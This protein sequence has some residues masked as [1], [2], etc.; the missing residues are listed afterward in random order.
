M[1]QFA[2]CTTQ[3]LHILKQPTPVWGGVAICE[4]FIEIKFQY[5]IN[6]LFDCICHQTTERHLALW[7]CHSRWCKGVWVSERSIGTFLLLPH[8]QLY[9]KILYLVTILAI[10]SLWGLR[11]Q[12]HDLIPLPHH[13]CR[14]CLHAEISLASI[15]WSDRQCILRL[16]RRKERCMF[17]DM[18]RWYSANRIVPGTKCTMP[19]MWTV[20][21]GDCCQNGNGFRFSWSRY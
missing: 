10:A 7:W 1:Y 21:L 12:N 19:Q 17:T 14:I 9:S 4:G 16:W 11:L 13:L 15:P 20:V 3:V 8:P 2:L 5:V 6:N 18:F